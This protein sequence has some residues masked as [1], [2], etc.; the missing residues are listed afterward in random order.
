MTEE[1]LKYMFNLVYRRIAEAQGITYADLKGKSNYKD[2]ILYMVLAEM[3]KAGLVSRKNGL[4]WAKHQG[5]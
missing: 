4:Y 2:A 5:P 1:Q 3:A